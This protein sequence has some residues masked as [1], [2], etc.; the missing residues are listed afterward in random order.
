MD[1]LRVVT[2]KNSIALGPQFGVAPDLLT[3]LTLLRTQGAERALGQYKL[4]EGD[5]LIRRFNNFKEFKFYS[6]RVLRGTMKHVNIH[7]GNDAPS[8]C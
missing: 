7:R 6:N 4:V 3:P 8:D 2:A 5:R 1:G